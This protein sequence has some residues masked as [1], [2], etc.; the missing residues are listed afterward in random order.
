MGAESTRYIS[1][2]KALRILYTNLSSLT[3]HTLALL[4]DE[5]ARQSVIDEISYLD[6]FEVGYGEDDSDSEGDE[7]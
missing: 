4:L 5:L 2:N 3:D 7:A 1:R 6:R